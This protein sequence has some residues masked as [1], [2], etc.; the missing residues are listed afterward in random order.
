MQSEHYS[1]REQ[2]ESEGRF[3]DVLSIFHEGCEIELFRQ[4]LY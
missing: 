3:S 1:F 2:P 4:P